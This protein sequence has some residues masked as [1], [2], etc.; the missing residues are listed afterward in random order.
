MLLALCYKGD[1]KLFEIGDTGNSPLDGRGKVPVV[2]LQYLSDVSEILMTNQSCSTFAAW[3]RS[4]EV[5]PTKSL[6]AAFC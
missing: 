2:L 6:I 3:V 4:L 5:K 1:W